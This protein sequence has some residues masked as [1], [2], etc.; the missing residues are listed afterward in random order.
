ML[1]AS[2]LRPILFSLIPHLS[3]LLD[4]YLSFPLRIDLLR[5]QAVFCVYFVLH[6][7]SFDW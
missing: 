6:Y 3:P 2:P 7:I 4:P 5:F 1:Y